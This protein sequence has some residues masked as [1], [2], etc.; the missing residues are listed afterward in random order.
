MGGN[1]AVD[2]AAVLPGVVDKIVLVDAIP[3]MRVLMMPGVPA[4]AMQYKSPYNE[5]MIK[6]PDDKFRQ[7]VAMM[8]GN[9]TLDKAKADSIIAWTLKADRKTYVYGY[10]D[11]LRLDLR[12][13]LKNVKAKTLILGAAN[14]NEDLIRKNYIDQ[15]QN[16]QEKT[17]EIAKDSRHF[18]MF[19]QP[20]W[21][22]SKINSFLEL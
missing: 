11:L 5:T 16:L 21:L 1:L 6:M 14:M 19:D 8:A 12:E 15:Y 4:S 20:E 13:D 18:I 10:T 17:L 22:Y 7:S 3:C 2:L 9:M